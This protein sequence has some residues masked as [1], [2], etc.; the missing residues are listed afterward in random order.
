MNTII[1]FG[2]MEKSVNETGS[3]V[4]TYFWQNVLEA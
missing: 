4:R 3:L 1:A 2:D